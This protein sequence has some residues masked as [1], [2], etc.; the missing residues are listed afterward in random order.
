MK[1]SLCKVIFNIDK[2]SSTGEKQ[3]FSEFPAFH[4]SGEECSIMPRE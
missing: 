3:L 2:K 4:D 1:I